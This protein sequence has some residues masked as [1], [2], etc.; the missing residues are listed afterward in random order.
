ML[1]GLCLGGLQLVAL[2]LLEVADDVKRE[3][4]ETILNSGAGTMAWNFRLRPAYRP[5]DVNSSDFVTLARIC[6]YITRA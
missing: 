1:D 2:L 3:T 5:L 6:V 4:V